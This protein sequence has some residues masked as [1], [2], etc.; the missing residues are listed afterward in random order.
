M[1]EYAK[2]YTPRKP[3]SGVYL[4]YKGDELFYIGESVDV[5]KRLKEHGFSSPKYRIKWIEED[6]TFCRKRLERELI[7][8][9][10]PSSNVAY[11]E[12]ARTIASRAQRAR[13]KNPTTLP[14]QNKHMRAEGI[15][16][17]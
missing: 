11:T 7:A 2:D 14:W 9:L 4:V 17:S 16:R 6:G 12:Q 3:R 13:Y 5:D 8:E 1:L 15:A 10:S